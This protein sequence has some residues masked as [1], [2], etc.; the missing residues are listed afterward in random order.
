M[1][2]KRLYHK[3]AKTLRTVP[4]ELTLDWNRVMY[5]LK[6]SYQ[7]VYYEKAIIWTM[8]TIVVLNKNSTKQQ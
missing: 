2:R 8:S 6:N 4:V 1:R 3:Q 7:K 5:L